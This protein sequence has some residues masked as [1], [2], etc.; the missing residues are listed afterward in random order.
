MQERRNFPLL[1]GPSLR[2]TAPKTRG[3][4]WDEF[5][6][7]GVIE[8]MHVNPVIFK[9]FFFVTRSCL[10]CCSFLIVFI[11][12]VKRYIWIVVFYYLWLQQHLWTFGVSIHIRAGTSKDTVTFALYLKCFRYSTIKLNRHSMVWCKCC[13]LL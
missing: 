1:P 5:C 3:W 6:Y 8:Y 9:M 7:Q 13:A 4:G 2:L 11:I 10:V 12:I